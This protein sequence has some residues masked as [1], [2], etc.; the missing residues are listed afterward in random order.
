MP[1]AL[2]A[3]AALLYVAGYPA[4]LGLW[5][6]S[7][8]ALV[9]LLWALERFELGPR[10]ALRVGM[11]FSVVAQLS[12]YAFLPETLLRFSGMP[13]VAC[14]LAH[15][16]LCIVQ[17]GGAALW[18][19]ALG[20]LRARGKSALAC[21]P[22]L[23]VAQ[24]LLWP[25]VFEAPL[26]AAV[27]DAPVLAQVA[28]LGGVALVSLLLASI[29]ASVAALLLGLARPAGRRRARPVA[30]LGAIA[31]VVAASGARLASVERELQ[32]AR[33]LRVGLVQASLGAEEKRRDPDRYAERYVQLSRAIAEP[34]DLLIWPETAL[35]RPV[36]ASV[37]A[38][39]NAHP[40]LDRVQAPLLT[41]AVTY[42]AGRLH[43]S[44][45]L[46]GAER[47]RLDRVD[48]HKLLP[49]AEVIPL[50]D[51]F[52]QLYDWIPGA[53]HF[54]PGRGAPVLEL[55]STKLAI[56]ICYEDMLPATVRQAALAGAELLVSLS[57]DAWFGES[58][59]AYTHFAA[60]RLRAI[61]LRRTLVRATNTGVTAVVDPTG[62]VSPHTLA[63]EHV[64]ATRVAEVAL[65]EG[66]TP[67]A[68]FGGG[69]ATAVMLAWL[70]L[71]L[72]TSPRGPTRAE[73][74]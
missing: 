16:A 23:W 12:G 49:F 26:G 51:R 39:G 36:P 66:Q 69:I 42:E 67:Y 72:L 41:G 27:H 45:L 56:F 65:L 21:A 31:V 50:G 68:R 54:T 22:P 73:A 53:G 10:A 43:N 5:P 40:S 47:Q 74:A 14:W 30:A 4:G 2:G 33:T 8:I 19:C 38:M 24:E 57:N 63:P 9:P 13:W 34:V 44:A 29:S 60:A 58:R 20:W 71:A 46:F 35:A 7:C 52:P 61:E 48:K 37:P 64:A 15:L 1:Y 11:L 55:G 25:S 32:H 59:A 6:L 17:G 3:L 62:R 18:L 70:A 28:E